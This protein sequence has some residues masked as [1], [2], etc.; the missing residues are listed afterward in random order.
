M[1]TVVVHG[2]GGASPTGY[3][4]KDSVKKTLLL[5]A[6]PVVAASALLPFFVVFFLLA[7]CPPMPR[8]PEPSAAAADAWGRSCQGA[9]L[10]W[11]GSAIK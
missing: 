5:L 4:S 10:R 2:A 3:L 1:L 6:A 8:R 11:V 7:S 9:W